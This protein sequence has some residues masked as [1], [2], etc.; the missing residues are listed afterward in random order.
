MGVPVPEALEGP[1]ERLTK[2]ER[3]ILAYYFEN[4]GTA[5][6]IAGRLG[7]APRT[8]YKA[9]YK[10]K[11]NLKRLGI[12]PSEVYGRRCAR[13]ER[14]ATAVPIEELKRAV[15]EVLE[16][17]VGFK[18]PLSVPDEALELLISRVGELS[19]SL[20]ILSKSI[21]R[22]ASALSKIDV[23]RE[24][25]LPSGESSELPS[26]VSGNPWLGVLMS[27]GAD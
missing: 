8:V 3:E 17:L 10:Y 9:H 11:K 20:E 1:S 16:E 7:V 19:E 26:F 6:E 21:D 12:D 25:E 23:P 5:K 14:R 2:T 4:G 15:R 18:R 27:R 24:L 22:L 13:A